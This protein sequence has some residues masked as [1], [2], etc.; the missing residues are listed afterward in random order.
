M[1]AAN[2]P[3]HPDDQLADYVLNALPAEERAEVESRLAANSEEAERVERLLRTVRALEAEAEP[4]DP[5]PGLAR[6]AVARTARHLVEHGLLWTAVDTQETLR[7]GSGL[8]KVPKPRPTPEPEEPPVVP[9]SGAASSPQPLKPP[10]AD[11]LFPVWLRRP[12]TIV[13]VLIVVLT[14]G[15]GV[16]AIG[17]LREESQVRGCQAQL[18]ELHQALDGYGD[19]NHGR[20]P[21]VGTATVPVAGALAAELVQAGQLPP[22]HTPRC[23]VAPPAP[24][25]LTGPAEPIGYAYT[26]GYLNPAGQVVGLRRDAGGVRGNDW[27]P[28]AAD[29]TGPGPSPVHARGQ[30]VLFAGGTVRYTTTTAAGAN[31]DHIYANEAGLARAGLHLLDTS[32]GQPGDRP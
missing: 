27:C 21:Q 25:T 31:G 20:Y 22:E 13:A 7:P 5:P 4:I 1:N 23:P 29:L 18:R 15:T 10:P 17:K 3:R 28:I 16:T 26:L 6:A 24:L 8:Q 11:P 9:A 14:V 19:V 32:L 12:D 30:N 2:D